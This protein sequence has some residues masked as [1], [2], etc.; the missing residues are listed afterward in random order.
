MTV[1]FRLLVYGS[2]EIVVDVN[3][4]VVVV[5]VVVVVTVVNCW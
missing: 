5:V 3:M 2:L 4:P 1:K